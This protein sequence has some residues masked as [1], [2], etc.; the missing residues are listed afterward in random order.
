MN[1]KE[2][3]QDIENIGQEWCLC[4]YEWGVDDYITIQSSQ[5]KL[6][7]CAVGK[8]TGG[9]NGGKLRYEPLTKLAVHDL[10][11]SKEI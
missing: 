11:E 1:A 3:L 2:L 6:A 7:L 4:P 9:Q 10:S 5:G 8:V